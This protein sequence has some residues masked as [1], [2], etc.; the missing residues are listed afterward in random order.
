MPALRGLSALDRKL[1]RDAWHYR[2]QL[3]A[4]AAVVVCGIALFVSLRSMNGYLRSSR[5]AYYGSAR[6]ADLFVS[7][8]RAPLRVARQ[9]AEIRGVVSADPRIVTEVVADVPGLPE[10]ATVRLVSIPVPAAPMLNRVHL[11][12]GRWPSEGRDGEVIASRAFLSANALTLGDS[13][14]VVLNGRWRWLHIVGAG[15]SP[16]YVYEIADAGVFPDNRHFGVVW[17]G[18]PALE[19]ALDLDG[20]FNDMTLAIVAVRDTQAVLDAVDTLLAPFGARGAYERDEQVSHQFLTGEIDETKVTAVLLPAIFLGVTAFLVHVV[21]SRLVSM[22]REQ[23][24]TLK[25][26]GYTHA[27]IARHYLLL[28]LIPVLGGS[29][30]GVVLGA[31]LASGLAEVYARFYQFPAAPYVLQGGIAV[32]AVVVGG[33][34]GIVGALGAVARGVRLRPAEAMRPE[35]PRRF[36]HAAFDGVM[37][38]LSTSVR[39]FVIVRNLE[40]KPSKTLLSIVGLALA[41]GLVIATLSMYDAIDAIMEQQFYVVD[42]GDVTVTF[43]EPSRIAALRALAR[44]PGVLEVEGFRAVPIRVRHHA[45][46]RRSVLF[47]LPAGGALRRLVGNDQVARDAPESGLLL[48]SS[49]ATRV[50]ATTGDEVDVHLLE[51]RRD[52]VKLTVAGVTDDLLGSAAYIA[53]SALRALEGSVELYT[54]ASLRVDARERDRLFRELKSLP[55]VSGVSIRAVTLEG[56]QQTIEESFGIALVVTLGFACVIAAGIVYNG[57]RV[58]LS[59]RGRELASLRVLGFTRREVAAMLLGEQVVLTVI[60]FPVAFAIAYL[61]GWL[62][63]VRF[64][65]ALFRIPVVVVPTSYLLGTV[66]VTIAAVASAWIVRRRIARL[67]LIAVL[68]TRE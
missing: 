23:I 11:A 40:R 12:M 13:I 2:G 5:D 67:D 8:R 53:P 28:A 20:A 63:T 48:A 24:A 10:P 60:S 62:I 47:A 33:G 42:R 54:G 17:I 15:I 25:A 6:F 21:L 26:F 57:A 9:A 36:R 64:E 52:V 4:I 16:E 56:F 43:R 38:R 34:A 50:G 45:R 59:E 61:L 41:G 35:A 29:A 65:S 31:W 68:K 32:A 19:S 27:A 30:I 58:A 14:G 22:Q 39:A 51:G 1:L 49:L 66:A 44:Q 55:E 7:V 37:Q 46:D 18:R 3:G